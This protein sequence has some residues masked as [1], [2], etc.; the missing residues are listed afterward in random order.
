MP[1]WD[2]RTFIEYSTAALVAACA[3]PAMGQGGAPSIQMDGG[4][5]FVKSARYSFRYTQATDNFTILDAKGRTV[6]SGLLQPM[7]QASPIA[8]GSQVTTSAGRA[9]I[10]IISGNSISF[11]Y[12]N[13]NGHASVRFDMRFDEQGFWLDPIH[14]ESTVPEDVVCLHYFVRSVEAKPVADLRATIITAPGIAENAAISPIQSQNMRLEQSFSLGHSGFYVAPYTHQQWGLPVHYFCTTGLGTDAIDGGRRDAYTRFRSETMTCGLADLPQGDI[15]LDLHNGRSTLWMDYR[16]DIW[17]HLRTPGVVNL[18]STLAFA[19]GDDQYSSITAYYMLLLEAGIVKRK[20]NSAGKNAVVCASQFCTWG[21]QVMRNTGKDRL[22][23]AFLEGLYA[24]MKSVGM[25]AKVF[26]VD[27]KWEGR[28]GNLE[29]DPVRMPHFVEFLDR[30]RA[31]GHHVGL[32]AAFMRCEDPAD[33]DLTVKHMLRKPDGSPHRGGGDKYYILDFT[34]PE[35]EKVLTE[36]A[37]A[38]IR[39]YKPAV[40]KFDFGYE[41]PPMRDA[42]PHDMQWAGERLLKRGLEIVVGALRAENPDVVVMYYQLS[43]LF[44]EYFDLHSTDD[45]YL[46]AGEYDLEANRRIYFASILS[47]LGIPTYGSSG[48]DWSSSPAIWF[49]SVVSGSIGSLNDFNRDEFGEKATPSHIALFNGLAQTLRPANLFQVIP[50]PPARPEASTRGARCKSWARVEGGEVTMVAQ[51]PPS[52][53]DGDMLDHRAIDSRIETLIQTQVPIVVASTTAE[54]IATSNRL[55]IV[56]CAEGGA[57]LKRSAGATAS[58]VTHYFGGRSSTTSAKIVDGSLRLG[59]HMA[60]EGG[61]PVEW[62]EITIS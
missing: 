50:F 52:F 10:P 36:R 30:V 9:R 32:W 41:M 25:N 53:D 33:L 6:A 34:Q 18:G 2:R 51:R 35:V 54:G 49:D 11:V 58:I 24:E 40:V 38:F 22:T 17:H 19:F 15:F 44:M 7:V 28:Y 39:R 13:V 3:R 4:G 27:D 56:A 48:Y 26:S 47:Q 55:A 62:T 37:R 16:S 61:Q 60:G 59:F 1:H 12:E 21:A 57:V 29:H 5:L 23:E 14:Y 20:E 42:A 46:A 31:E 8:K 43:P 45:L